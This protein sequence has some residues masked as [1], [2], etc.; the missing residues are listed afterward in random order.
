[1]DSKEEKY[2]IVSGDEPCGKKYS[3]YEEAHAVAN[4]LACVAPGTKFFVLEAIE[5]VVSKSITI[6]NLR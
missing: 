4:R 5:Y 1:M 2:W 6:V 3:S